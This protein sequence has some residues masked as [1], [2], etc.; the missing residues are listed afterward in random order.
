MMKKYQV[1]FLFFLIVNCLYLGS[2]KKQSEDS[3][4]NKLFISKYTHDT[5]WTVN[6]VDNVDIINNLTKELEKNDFSIYA[7][8][9]EEDK[10][11]YSFVSDCD[12]QIQYDLE[13]TGM[14]SYSI[15]SN[16]ESVRYKR[17]DYSNKKFRRYNYEFN[18][19]VYEFENEK[20]ASNQFEILENAS[21]SGQGYCNKIFN[22]KFVLKKNEIFEFSTMDEKSLNA[23]R[24]Y[25]YFIKNQ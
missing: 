15:K 10:P 16:S 9:V 1:R 20:V 8:K 7:H 25:A 4:L 3:F 11:E 2:C 18:V 23:M 13:K 17:R 6:M 22:T 19:S 21:N 5:I 14:R 24:N 12:K